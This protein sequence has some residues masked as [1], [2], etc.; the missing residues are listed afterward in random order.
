VGTTTDIKK[1]TAI[2]G[3]LARATEIQQAANVKNAAETTRQ[4]IYTSARARGVRRESKIAGGP[5]GVN[6]VVKGNPPFALIKI[7]G[8]FHLVES[9]TKA[10]Q[11][12]RKGARAKGK[13][14]RRINKQA[15]LNEVFGGKGAYTGGSLKL[16]D[17]GFRKVVRHPGTK[18]KGIFKAAKVQAR[19]AVPSVMAL[20]TVNA[21]KKALK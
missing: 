10:H 17:G 20:G 11:I 1:F 2:F 16:L 19:A 14:S 5:W 15:I 12:Y 13:G 9:D 8:P 18:G 4:I 6:Y 7:T 21:W 3:K